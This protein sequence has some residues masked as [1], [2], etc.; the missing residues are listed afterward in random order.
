MSSPRLT[1]ALILQDILEKKLFLSDVRSQLDSFDTSDRALANMLI[2]TALR[3]LCFIKKSLKPH[4]KKKLPIKAKL[5]EYLMIVAAVEILFLNTPD[6][7]VLNSY[8]ELVK[9]QTDKYIAGFVNA[10]LR[11]ICSDKET[12]LK[13]DTSTFFPDDFIKLLRQSYG[14][15]TIRKIEQ[16]SLQEPALDISLKFPTEQRPNGKTLPN[17]SIR[18]QN[19]APIPT[20]PGFNEGT[21][22]VQDFSASLAAKTILPHIAGRRVLDLC[23]APGGKTAQ[24]LSAGAIVDAIDISQPRLKTLQNNLER[25]HLQTNQTICAD[26]LNFLQ[27]FHDAPYDAI[28]L[29][30][31]CSATGTLRRHPEIVHIKTPQDIEKQALL[32]KQILQHITPAVKTGGYL[33]YCTCSLDKKEGEKQIT[34]FLSA[35]SAFKILHLKDRFP[36]WPEEI[37]TPEGFIRTLP[38]HLNTLGGVDGFFVALLQR[39]K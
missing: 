37:F 8:V 15:K 12:L 23:A 6:Y 28:L 19:N 39:I 16:A 25:L 14:I 29:D 9:K 24:L 4:I 35:S 33:V 13:Q 21:W 38:F 7:A 2:L 27:N 3:R 22:W 17:G 18:I 30:A 11:K 20:L 32:Q 36:E 31:P 10:V 34:D 1:A 5:A 26:A